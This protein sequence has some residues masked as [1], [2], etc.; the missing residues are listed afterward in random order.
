MKTLSCSAAFTKAA[1]D[2]IADWTNGKNIARLWACDA[3]LWTGTDEAQWLGWLDI[4]EKQIAQLDSFKIF[5]QD[6]QSAGFT[7]AALLGMGGSSLCPEVLRLTFGKIAGFPDL[8]ILDSTDPAQ[9]RTLESKLD[10]AKTLFIV[11]SKSGS[12]LE[13]NVFKDYFFDRTGRNGAQFI[14]ITDPGSKMQTVAERDGFRKIFFGLPAIGGR[15]SA[16]SNFGVIPAAAMGIDVKRLLT[17]SAEMMQNCRLP[18]EA[19]PGL[20]LGAILG[21]LALAGRDKLTVMAS[22]GIH[23]LGAWL[24]QLIAESTGKDGKAIIPVDREPIGTPDVY[25]HDRVFVYQRLASAPDPRQDRQAGALAQA[26]H[27]V[28]TITVP[29]IYHIGAEFFR[30]EFATAIAGALLKINPF[31]QPDVEASKI[32]TRKLTDQFEATGQ[33]PSE[34]PAFTDAGIKVYGKTI[35]TSLKD[36]LRAHLGS[37]VPGDYCALLAY[38][39]MNS[40]NEDVMTKL[41]A[42]IRDKKHVATC[43]GFG[44]RF[45]HSTGQAYKGGPGTGVFLQITADDAHDLAVPG[46]KYSFGIV[47]SAQSRGD[48]EVLYARNRR[49][50]RFHL[51]KDVTSGLAKLASAIEAALQ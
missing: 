11:A 43:V 47:K 4:A 20:E 13:P 3:S 7:H 9:V 39:E 23:D 51:E 2:V 28:I 5:A 19:N 36:C 46:Q 14:A 21:S 31:N 1:D 18:G 15:F 26:G 48:L 6:I 16:L 25:G 27:P 8:H 38:I 32:E 34:T 29:D 45:L 41:R 50:L 17:H 30:W 12:T 10:L 40:A 33:L 35:A 22:P 44:P 24:E 37:I 49:A 42:Q